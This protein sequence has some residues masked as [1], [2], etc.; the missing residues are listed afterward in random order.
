MTPPSA[1]PT[2]RAPVSIESSS[3]GEAVARAVARDGEP[4]VPSTPIVPQAAPVIEQ[5][6]S[7]R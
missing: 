7:T 3:L 2:L 6:D 5:A 1:G 4:V